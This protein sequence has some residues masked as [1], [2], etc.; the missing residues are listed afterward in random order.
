[1]TSGLTDVTPVPLR[2]RG[3]VRDPPDEVFWN[4][5]GRIAG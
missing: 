4:A 1:M 5:T 2:T 3:E